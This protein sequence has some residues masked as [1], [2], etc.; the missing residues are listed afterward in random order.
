MRGRADAMRF[1]LE[2][3]WGATYD[4]EAEMQDSLRGSED[5]VE[6]VTAFFEK[7]KPEFKGK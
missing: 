1:A 6:G 5:C 7:R 2:N 4:I 3:S